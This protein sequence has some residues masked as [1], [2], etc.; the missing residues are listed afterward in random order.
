MPNVPYP[1]FVVIILRPEAD[2]PVFLSE[3]LFDIQFQLLAQGR[4]QGILL[5]QKTK[6]VFDFD[7]FQS[8]G[9]S[10]D[11][12]VEFNRYVQSADLRQPHF[13]FAQRMHQLVVR[14]FVGHFQQN[15]VG[16][17]RGILKDVAHTR[18]LF[19]QLPGKAGAPLYEGF[20]DRVVDIYDLI[21]FDRL[22]FLIVVRSRGGLCI[23]ENR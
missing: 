11:L 17:H 23:V 10:R 5:G 2:R 21:F 7:G 13:H 22:F 1:Y 9:V 6:T 16:G 3:N 19:H 12:Y 14:G 18:T 4:Q 20:F 15:P 8:L